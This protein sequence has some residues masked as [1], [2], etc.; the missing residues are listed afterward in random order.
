MA[1]SSLLSKELA[2]AS[3]HSLPDLAI[4]D[5]TYTPSLYATGQWT[6]I[7]P[8]LVKWGQMSQFAPPSGPR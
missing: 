5:P 8:Y 4:A 6:N 2:L 1:G 3:T 7:K